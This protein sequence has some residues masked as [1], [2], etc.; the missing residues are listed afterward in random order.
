EELLAEGK[1]TA[2]SSVSETPGLVVALDRAIA[3]LKR[4]A[5]E[6]D[7]LARAVG[8]NRSKSRDLLEVYRRYQQRLR[9]AEN[10]DVE[11]Q[12][13]Q[14]RD[15]LTACGDD[16]PTGLEGFDAIVVDG[17]TDFTPTQLQILALTAKRAGKTLITLPL[18]EDRRGRMWHWT[19]RAM[20]NLRE[21]FGGELEEIEICPGKFG[22]EGRGSAPL[23]AL[24]DSV[25]DF[26]AAP[27][28]IPEGL[29]LIAASGIEAEVAA[30]CR[31][32]KRLLLAEAPAG[33]IAVLVRSL[34]QYRPAIERIFGEC[35]IPVAA[36]PQALIDVPIVRLAFDVAS[37][38]PEFA[39]RDVLRVIKN[40]Y[41]R[42]QA[43]GDFDAATTAAA[44]MLIREGNVLGGREAYGQAARRLAARTAPADEDVDDET[45]SLGPLTASPDLLESAAAM[46]ERLFDL[47][48]AAVDPPGLGSLAEQLQLTTAA[49][50]HNEPALIG[51]DL[52]ALAA[53][54]ET[55]AGLREPFPTIAA[56]REALAFADCPAARGESLADV[57]DVLDARAIRYDHVF[58]L[59]VSEGI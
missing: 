24:W 14:A 21:A 9:E 11:G 36:A 37:I 47:A 15:N 31:R 8:R 48:A 4:A 32:V 22:P 17:F 35:D 33:S 3:E 49:C 50:A 27:A 16:G 45:V 54:K 59:G 42:P 52:R 29:C 5:I 46:L 41:F 6:P 10:Y 28:E 19:Q 40:S 58:L 2:L 39:F 23:G 44:E 13:W 57:L 43:L 53:L 34:G 55:L 56:I 38:A 26:D 1:L 25:F 30:A 20:V 51:R 7:A 12:M 18:D